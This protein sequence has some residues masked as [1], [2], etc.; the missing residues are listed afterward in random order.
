[1]PDSPHF[2]LDEETIHAVGLEPSGT[3]LNAHIA[4]DARVFK[5]PHHDDVFVMENDLYGNEMPKDSC[6]LVFQGQHGLVGRH[7]KVDTLR[8]SSVAEIHK[9]IEANSGG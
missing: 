9:L 1:M 5:Y 4:P 8:N 3:S 2:N 6:F 7:M